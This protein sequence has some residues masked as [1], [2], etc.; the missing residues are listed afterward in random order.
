M[1]LDLNSKSNLISGLWYGHGARVVHIPYQRNPCS[2]TYKREEE[3]EKPS[4]PES[5]ISATMEKHTYSGPR[6][7]GDRTSING[8]SAVEGN[9]CSPLPQERMYSR[10]VWGFLD[11][12]GSNLLALFCSSCKGKI[13]SPSRVTRIP[14]C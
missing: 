7:G 9:P 6:G 10:K 12:L 8:S 13:C 2:R 5:S 1:K 14:R 4:G 3:E 11:K